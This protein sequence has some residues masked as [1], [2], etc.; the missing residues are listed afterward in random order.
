MKKL[1]ARNR[2]LEKEYKKKETT[3]MNL[4]RGETFHTNPY[5]SKTSTSLTPFNNKNRTLSPS[6]YSQQQQQDLP[7][8]DEK[9]RIDTI[10]G[11][12]SQ[13]DNF[14]NFD[15]KSPER[16]EKL[17]TTAPSNFGLLNEQTV[18]PHCNSNSN[19]DSDIYLRR[20]KDLLIQLEEKT[21][22]IFQ[23]QEDLNL[24]HAN[25]E[26]LSKDQYINFLKSRLEQLIK[27]S[28]R[29]FHNY[30]YIR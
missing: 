17:N 11:E 15:T 25:N 26:K 20:E 10:S 30:V 7:S 22:Q 16:V 18:C 29:Y 21:N 6:S 23:L 8:F 5:F 3:L 1:Y 14:S 19:S 12:L 24:Q 28:Q 4:T 13:I 27:D 9:S 2:F